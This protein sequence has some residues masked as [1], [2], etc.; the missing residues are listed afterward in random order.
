M[1]NLKSTFIEKYKNTKT[2]NFKGFNTGKMILAIVKLRIWLMVIQLM[3][4][5]IIFSID[6]FIIYSYF[7][8]TVNNYR[9]FRI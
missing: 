1:H 7:K 2:N 3:D 9:G 6:Q 4:V 5:I 8:P